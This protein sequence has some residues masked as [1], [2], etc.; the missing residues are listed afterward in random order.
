MTCKPSDTIILR[1]DVG[2]GEQGG[3]E[4]EREAECEGETRLLV[5]K[6]RGRVQGYCDQH[7]EKGDRGR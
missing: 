2:P 1:C 3:A 6:E 4:G 5:E 7:R